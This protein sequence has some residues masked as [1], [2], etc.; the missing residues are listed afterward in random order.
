MLFDRADGCRVWDLDGREYIDLCCSHGATLLGHG[1]PRVRRAVERRWTAAPPAPT[2]TSCTPSWPACCARRCPAASASASPAPAPRRR[3]TAC[4]WPAPSPA[5]RNCSKF[6]GNFHGYHDQ[7]MY[8]I[9]TPAD[10][11]G[12]EDGADRLSRLDRHAR[13]A[14]RQ[15]GRR[16]LQPARPARGGASPARPGAGRRHLRADLLQRRLH[17]ADAGVPGRAAPADARARRAADLRRSAERLPHGARRR[18]GIS[19]RHAGPV[20]AGQGGRRRLSAERVRR[21][22]RHHGPADADGRLPAQRHLQ[23]PSSS[24][25]PPAWPP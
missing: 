10:R 15:P 21:P 13:R 19:R 25:S 9:G 23:R 17:P 7:V 24:P 18:A 3:C 8:A 6:E 22:A 5:A 2:R 20:Y 16:A 14:G 1:D 12:P 4:A 11:L